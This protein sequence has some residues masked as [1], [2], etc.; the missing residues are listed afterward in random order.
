MEHERSFLL[1]RH[2]AKC[3]LERHFLLNCI[4]SKMDLEENGRDFKVL[5]IFIYLFVYAFIYLIPGF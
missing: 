2:F 5:L 4:R 1:P 3:P